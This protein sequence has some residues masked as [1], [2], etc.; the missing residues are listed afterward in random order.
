MCINDPKT[1]M[2]I[3]G[4]NI[5]CKNQKEIEGLWFELEKIIS[6]Y[7]SFSNEEIFSCK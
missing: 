3:D 5:V 6:L 2:S 7:K 4:D 1:G